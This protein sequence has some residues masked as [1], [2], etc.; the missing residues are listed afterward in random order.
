LNSWEAAFDKISRRSFLDVLG[1]LDVQPPFSFSFL[2]AESDLPDFLE[3][4]LDAQGVPCQQPVEFPARDVALARD[5]LICASKFA[6]VLQASRA[7]AARG[8]VTWAVVE[9]YHATFLAVRTLC[10]LLGIIP[11]SIGP[12]TVLVDFRPEA[13]TP[14]DAIKF[15]K[16]FG[17]FDSPIRILAPTPKHLEQKHFWKLAERLFKHAQASSEDDSVELDLLEAAARSSPGAFR[18]EVLY[19]PVSWHWRNDVSLLSC[20]RL[21]GSRVIVEKLAEVPDEM[22]LLDTTHTL[23]LKYLTKLTNEIG[24]ALEALPPDYTI[25][26]PPHILVA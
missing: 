13:G 23:L 25:S 9:S 12:R 24:L 16:T 10:A 5:V 19:N 21:V 7:N 3:V 4:Q 2:D 1:A 11:Y 26:C 6:H 22:S 17:K 8:A 18:N 20:T 15:R 14:Q